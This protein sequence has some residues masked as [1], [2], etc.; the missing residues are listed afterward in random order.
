VWLRSEASGRYERGVNR[1]ELETAC[2]RALSLIQEL[3]A[4]VIVQQEISDYRP[5]ISTWSHSIYLRL[6]KI[7]EVLG[8]I[9]LGQETGELQGSDVEKIL[10]ALGCKLVKTDERNWTVTV[11][12]Y[13]YRDLERE[14]DLIE[15]IARLY[16][17]DKFCDTLPEKSEAGYLS[18]DQELIRRLRGYLRA[19]GLRN[20]QPYALI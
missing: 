6:D 2:N 9:E 12:P 15:E 13:R 5:D 3:A 11:P 20:I 19:E 1:A 4:G 10:T 16:G 18:L 8:P 14:I 17:Y 7:N